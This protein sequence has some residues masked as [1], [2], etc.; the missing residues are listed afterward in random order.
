MRMV[1]VLNGVV[2]TT[3]VLTPAMFDWSTGFLTRALPVVCLLAAAVTRLSSVVEGPRTWHT[4]TDIGALL[5]RPR[6]TRVWI[7]M[8]IPG[9]DA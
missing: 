3:S 1:A 7:L 8:R 6:T 4:G 2:C 5:M 9:G